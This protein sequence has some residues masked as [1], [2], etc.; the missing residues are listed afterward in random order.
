MNFSG[1]I[2]IAFF[3]FASVQT[4]A[5]K[6]KVSGTVSKNSILLGEPFELK[7]KAEYPEKSR[8]R[9]RL[10]SIPH[11][12]FLEKPLVDSSSSNG[13]VT[14]NARYQLTSF[15]SGHWVILDTIQM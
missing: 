7:V 13:I 5:Q 1:K 15:D 10:D 9:F 6:V 8:S 14:L 3:L 2:F 12:E 4:N 11:F